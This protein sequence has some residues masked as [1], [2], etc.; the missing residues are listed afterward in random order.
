M[1]RFIVT[2]PGKPLT[3]GYKQREFKWNEELNCFVYEGRTFGEAE[4]NST[5]DR[6]IKTNSDFHLKVKLVSMSEELDVAIPAPPPPPPRE[7]TLEEALETVRRL[8]PHR[9]RA[10]TGPKEYEITELPI[11]RN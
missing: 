9:L 6:V 5:I 1:A 7:I 10:K 2:I 8:A 3:H 11:A 4:F